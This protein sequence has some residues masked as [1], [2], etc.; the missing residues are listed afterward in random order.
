M[1]EI[2]YKQ[3]EG[4]RSLQRTDIFISSRLMHRLLRRAPSTCTTTL[5]SSLRPSPI[6]LLDKIG[7]VQGT[8]T[9]HAC[10]D[11]I[12]VAP[13]NLVIAAMSG[14]ATGKR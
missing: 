9:V 2:V 5:R 3:R 4:A 12:C 10:N 11:Q 13:A 14:Q 1:I 8:V 6:I 7:T